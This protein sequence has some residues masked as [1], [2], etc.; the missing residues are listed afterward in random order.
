M[1]DR[2]N[3]ETKMFPLGTVMWYVPKKQEQ[4]TIEELP[5]EQSWYSRG[6]SWASSKMDNLPV[7]GSKSRAKYAEDQYVLCD[8]SKYKD[9]MF[10]DLITDFESLYAHLPNRYLSAAGVTL[11]HD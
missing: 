9:E 8:G 2:W 1:G 6:I 5:Q 4:Q 10:Q 3:K 7:I 11:K